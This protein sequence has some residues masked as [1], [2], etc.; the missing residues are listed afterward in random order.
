VAR[1]FVNRQHDS[2]SRNE[3]WRPD[4]TLHTVRHSI[5]GHEWLDVRRGPVLRLGRLAG[6]R[7]RD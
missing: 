1:Q 4:S 5:L 3:R 6:A 2:V 7:T